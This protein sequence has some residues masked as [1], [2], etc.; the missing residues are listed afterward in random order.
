M[1]RYPQSTVWIYSVV[2]LWEWRDVARKPA[3]RDVN[4]QEHA[5]RNALVYELL[6]LWQAFNS[7]HQN[8]VRAGSLKAPVSNRT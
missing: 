1:S 8:N 4:S 5:G 3:E 6:L 2:Q 7:W